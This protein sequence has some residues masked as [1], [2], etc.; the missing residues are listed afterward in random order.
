MLQRR[1]VGDERRVDSVGVPVILCLDPGTK[2]GWCLRGH[3]PTT[4]MISGTWNLGGGR[5]DG[6]GMRFDTL[7][8]EKNW[9]CAN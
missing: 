6:A 9:T 3:K 5:F 8:L 1:G 2:T 4:P 7:Q